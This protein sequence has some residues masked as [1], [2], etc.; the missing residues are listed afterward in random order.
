MFAYC[1]NNP[2]N[3]SDNSGNAPQWLK[4]FGNKVLNG[5]KSGWNIAINTAGK[6]WNTAKKGA[7]KVGVAFLSSLQIEGGFGFGLG[8]SSTIGPVKLNIGAYHDGVTLGFKNTKNYTSIRGSAGVGAKAGK[9]MSLSISTDYEHRYETNGVRDLD[10]HNSLTMPWSVYNCSK[11]TKTPL[12]LGIP[13]V[14][15]LEGDFA[16]GLFIG[17]DTDLHLGIGGHFTI[18]WDVDEFI[19]VLTE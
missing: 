18:G 1:G 2:V 15:P 12:Q 9:N 11:T 16:D 3:M 10:G 19:K 8:G 7:K 17:I 14:K 6:G 5:L 4:N 13:L